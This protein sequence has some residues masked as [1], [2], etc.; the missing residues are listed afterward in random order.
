VPSLGERV[1]LEIDPAGVVDVPVWN[2][3]AA[4]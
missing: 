3:D 4:D 2:G 1:G